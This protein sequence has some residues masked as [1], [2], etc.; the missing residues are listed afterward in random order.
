MHPADEF[1]QIKAEIAQ[2]KARA[3][4]LRAGFLEDAARRRSNQYEILV[5][6]QRRRRFLRERLPPHILAD[7]TLWEERVA[8]VVTVQEV[9]EIEEDFVLVE[10]I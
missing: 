7:Q 3:E 6:Q 1:A 5:K 10:E 9:S 4:E 2:L 8:D